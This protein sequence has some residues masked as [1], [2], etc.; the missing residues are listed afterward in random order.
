MLSH[1]YGRRAKRMHRL[2]TGGDMDRLH[3]QGWA[4]G[5][6]K[7]ALAQYV[8]VKLAII[9]AIIMVL[10][11]GSTLALA[12]QSYAA[13]LPGEKAVSSKTT[14]SERN[15][16]PQGQGVDTPPGSAKARPLGELLNPDGTV[17]LGTGFSG[18]LDVAG[19]KMA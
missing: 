7:A 16:G 2:I 15:T 14:G 9:A 19:Y 3:K 1:T 8:T 12:S 6:A 11:A 13:P 5:K 10:A 17:N 18:S 4:S